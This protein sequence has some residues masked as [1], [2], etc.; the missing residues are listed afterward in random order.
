MPPN[1]FAPPRSPIRRKVMFGF[2][3]I[4][5]MLALIAFVSFRSNVRYLTAARTIE[6]A[7]QVLEVE[8][9][10][11][12]NL[13]ELENLRLRYLVTGD[14]ELQG[15]YRT[16]QEKV[17]KSFKQLGELVEVETEQARLLASIQ[18]PLTQFFDLQLIE[19]RARREAGPQGPTEL[20]Y[21]SKTTELADHIEGVLSQFETVQNK[22]LKERGTDAD[23][24]AN[25]NLFVILTGTALTFITLWR[26]GSM[27]FRDFAAR[28]RAEEALAN[29]H[30]LFSSIIDTMPDHVF[31][32]DVKGRY[33][34]DNAAHRRYLGLAGDQ[35]IEGT[36][37]ADYFPADAVVQFMEDDRQLLETGKPIFNRE[38]PVL[39]EG[40]V[41][42][43]IETTKVPLRDT[44]GTI[45]GLVGVSSD[46]SER[47]LAEE[48]LRSFA[49]QLARSNAELQNFANVASHDLQ[50]PLRKIQAFGDRLRAK[51]ADRLGDLGLDYLSRMESAAER[52]Q[53]LIQDLLKLSRVVT[54]AQP[55]V[56]CDLGKVIR[57]VLSDLEVAIEKKDARIEVGPLPTIQG[58]PVQLWQLFQNLVSNSMKFQR[59]GVQ[60]VLRITGRVYEAPS[61]FIAGVQ[62]GDRVAEITVQDNGIGF[63]EKFAEQIFVV[64]Q[65]LH[66][67][68]EYE[69]TG[70]GLA[71]CR[72]ITDRHAGQ[73]VAKA[74]EGKGATFIVTLPVQQPS[75]K[76]HE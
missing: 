30:N 10:A 58:D 15:E 70:I 4:F 34:L 37:A 36:T 50:E 26:A 47:K 38:V 21:H 49:A 51:C 54:Q 72:K 74:S 53:R 18:E 13:V 29:E 17:E 59:P 73:I 67:R 56:P 35:I 1:N 6:Q 64:F 11:R 16:V 41:E 27:I 75:L 76:A 28:R 60:P 31:V 42:K 19:M 32:K 45:V 46:I 7:R 57:E 39:R 52:M 40:A 2:G 43:W 69:G 48:K 12:R 23:R 9:R 55:F 25:Q 20:I 44:D 62:A 3:L 14:E 5:A 71:V 65:R 22:V 33:I 66:S 61:H 68:D 8:E 24:I 63:D